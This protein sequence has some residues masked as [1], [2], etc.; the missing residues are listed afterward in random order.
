MIPHAG[1][2]V[3]AVR[4]LAISDEVADHLWNIDGGVCDIAGMRAGGL[5]GSRRH[6][7]GPNQYTGRRVRR[8]VARARRQRPARP[9]DVLI[10]H[11]SMP[12]LADDHQ[13]PELEPTVL[14]A[15]GP[16]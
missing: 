12:G 2:Q 14:L 5:G 1:G 13:L 7:P 3:R 10:A 16:G 15:A 9:V 4:M 11:A 6:Q 8:L